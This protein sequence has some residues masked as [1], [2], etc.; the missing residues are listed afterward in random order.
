MTSALSSPRGINN[1]RLYGRSNASESASSSNSTM[2]TNSYKHK[3]EDL[4]IDLDTRNANRKKKRA[5]SGLINDL[6]SFTLESPSPN[7]VEP[8]S[9]IETMR[10][11]RVTNMT[12]PLDEISPE[13]PANKSPGFDRAKTVKDDTSKFEISL[14]AIDSISDDTLSENT[15]LKPK[16]GNDNN[17]Q[18]NIDELDD[19]DDLDFGKT[20][21]LLK[22]LKISNE[23]SK[24]GRMRRAVR[25]DS[26]DS[27]TSSTANERSRSVSSVSNS[28]RLRS[29]RSRSRKTSM[30][31]TASSTINDTKTIHINESIIDA[32]KELNN[33]IIIPSINE[34]DYLSKNELDN[35]DIQSDILAMISECQNEIS[36]ENILTYDN[37]I[38]KKDGLNNTLKKLSIVKEELDKELS[39]YK[40]ASGLLE[41]DSSKELAADV[42]EINTRI[43]NLV[44][45]LLT[46]IKKYNNEEMMLLNHKIALLN[47]KI[48]NKNSSNINDE[49]LEIL[50]MKL[51]EH[52]KNV[53]ILESLKI[54]IA[55]FEEQNQN[56]IEELESKNNII[57][58]LEDK[59]SEN[60][61]SGEI[62]RL[63]KELEDTKNEI[64]NIDEDLAYSLERLGN[65]ES[66]NKL[67][68]ENNDDKDEIIAK[69][70][71]ELN[72]L[73]QSMNSVD[74]SVIEDLTSER[75]KYKGL[76]LEARSK[77]YDLQRQLDA[78]AS[79]DDLVI[80][81]KE[82]KKLKAEVDQLNDKLHDSYVTIEDLE[83]KIAELNIQLDN[84]PSEDIEE[85]EKK[86]SELL[87]ENKQLQRTNA[88]VNTLKEKLFISEKNRAD[89]E[90]H[91]RSVRETTERKESEQDNQTKEYET[92]ITDL[93]IELSEVKNRSSHQDKT[94]SQLGQE[95]ASTAQKLSFKSNELSDLQMQLE[96]K[97]LKIE[98]AIRV[99]NEVSSIR[100]TLHNKDN[101][102][103]KLRSELNNVTE[104]FN[105]YKN[106]VK[107]DIENHEHLLNDFATLQ[108][109]VL[110]LKK[111][112]VSVME[113]V[114]D[115]K[116]REHIAKGK[117]TKAEREINS[118]QQDIDFLNSENDK[119]Q[120]RER[121]Q[122]MELEKLKSKVQ[123]LSLQSIGQGLSKKS[124]FEDA[125][126]SLRDDY[127]K[128][129]TEAMEDNKAKLEK[130]SKAR[131]L[132][133]L[134]LRKLKR[135]QSS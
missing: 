31:S 93:Q 121:E 134:E 125:T 74:N 25:A 94:L 59:L 13:T 68:K 11:L 79:P 108:N 50:E 135:K 34:I 101:E 85:Y 40:S 97:D 45:Q 23:H 66:D 102:L 5:I 49:E 92:R 28:G 55:S 42:E 73:K 133:E 27:I 1:P 88:E 21:E 20:E 57:K 29:P 46:T 52:E 83:A 48:N 69:L 111:S 30:A 100:D 124:T 22:S 16:S 95:L 116:Y 3:N 75:D 120:K 131:Q 123:D 103:S 89:I 112:K 24:G 117:L 110:E 63:K 65:L 64:E 44:Y 61:N 107:K 130:E 113:E 37:Y 114:D 82:N 106:Q 6:K 67:L 8:D 19:L 14:N 126:E 60:D 33:S 96:E 58:R 36:N 128:L 47:W 17:T 62:S 84:I 56:M 26:F 109:V 119:Y 98:E 10:V 2:S 53:P 91:L 70:E 86:I 9:P 80:L 115:A 51:A 72:E 132:A 127:R 105:S 90:D 7:N 87:F 12:E 41:T 15:D 77:V 122:T 104:E 129:L 76:A 81:E 118:L 35:A 43:N 78:S 38:F 39:L 18:K 54:E 71:K 4:R 32:L 99:T